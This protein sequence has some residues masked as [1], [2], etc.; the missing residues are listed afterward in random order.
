MS[1]ERLPV[2]GFVLAGGKSSRMGRD[3]ALLE[4]GGRAMV[5]IAV[6]KLRSFCAAVS[7]VGEREDLAGFAPV[8]R[9][10]RVGC[11]PGAGIEAGL[12][13]CE[14]GWAMFVPVDVPLVPAELLRR[15]AGEVLSVSM[16]ISNVSVGANQPA[17]C[18]MRRDV[19]EEFAKALDTG[20]RRLSRLLHLAQ[21]EGRWT[22]WVYDPHELFGPDEYPSE[23]DLEQWFLNVNT[24]QDSERAESLLGDTEFNV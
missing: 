14:Q 1:G 16:S 5:E 12:K 4:F 23:A 17:F 3:K 8:V 22:H 11:G 10:E 2:H 20:E 18:M 19:L 7:I 21:G 6:E 13:A 24:P 9:G 15:W